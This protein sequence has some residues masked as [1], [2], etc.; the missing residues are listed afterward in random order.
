M[1][2]EK[3]YYKILGVERTATADEIKRAY[4]KLPLNIT[5]TEILAIKK[6]KRSSNKL[7]RRMTSCA[8]QTNAPD[9]TNLVLTASMV[10]EAL[11]ALVDKAWTSTTFSALSEIYLA[12][13][14]L[15]ALAVAA[16]VHNQDN[17]KAQTCA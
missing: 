17:T 16:E 5:L 2:D 12:D 9:T 14:D 11:A 6:L 4:K 3:D 1:A 7:L 13:M 8:I 10:L 15:A